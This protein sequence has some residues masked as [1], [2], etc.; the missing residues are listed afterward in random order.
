MILNYNVLFEKNGYALI[1]RGNDFKEY[2]VVSGLVA[3]EN[4]RYEGSDWDSTVY[5]TWKS[6]NGLQ[7]CLEVYRYVTEANYIIGVDLIPWN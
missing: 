4:R 5:Y 7:K 6:V 2:A 1:E 3:E